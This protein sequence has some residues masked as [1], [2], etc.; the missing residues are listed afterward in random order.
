MYVCVCG[1]VYV[2]GCICVCMGVYVYIH[3]CML[4]GLF[5]KESL[6]GYF[7]SNAI[8]DIIKRLVTITTQDN[9]QLPQCSGVIHAKQMSLSYI[10]V[11]WKNYQQ[12]FGS[13]GYIGQLARCTEIPSEWCQDIWQEVLRCPLNDM[14]GY[15]WQDV[16]RCPL[17]DV[18]I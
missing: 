17:S 18:R 12:I 10:Y 1:C 4:W 9:S 14:S 6:W 15:S 2:C 5:A 8:S 7:V 13:A 11:T 3:K 16:L